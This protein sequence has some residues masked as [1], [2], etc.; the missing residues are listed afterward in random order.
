MAFGDGFKNFTQWLSDGIGITAAGDWRNPSFGNYTN[1]GPIISNSAK[2]TK[3]STVDR[4]KSLGSPLSSAMEMEFAAAANQMKFQREANQK[5]MDFSAAE[6]EKNRLFQANSAKRAMQ[7]E[8]DQAKAAMD[9]SERMSNTSYQRA[10]KDMQAAG[11]NPILAV[12][13]GGASSPAG[14]SGSGFTS[15]GSS[16]SGV[17]SAGSKANVA[18]GK[19]SDVQVL[20]LIANTALGLFDSI[21]RLIRR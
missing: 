8:A 17:S 10:V 1:A 5:A 9:F 15:S 18:G 12:S 3:T 20:G 13:Q 7:F 14:M 2:S 21:T 19:S 6:A 11:L 16:A 4:F